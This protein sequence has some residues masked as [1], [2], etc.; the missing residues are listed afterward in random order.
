M[1]KLLL[2]HF[3]SIF[4]THQTLSLFLQTYLGCACPCCCQC[5]NCVKVHFL[6]HQHCLKKAVRYI[7]AVQREIQSSEELWQKVSTPEKSILLGGGVGA[8][9]RA[10]GVTVHANWFWL[11]DW[12]WIAFDAQA[13]D[14]MGSILVFHFK[15]CWLKHIFFSVVQVNYKLNV[16]WA[17]D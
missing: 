7:S 12:T 2:S 17:L 4:H 10:M 8:L 9:S 16:W 6:H 5:K 3:I 13:G 11:P 15:V 14:A 1:Y